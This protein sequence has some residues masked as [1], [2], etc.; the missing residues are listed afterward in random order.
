MKSVRRVR[1][2]SAIPIILITARGEE[3]Q[4]IAG[5][6][7]GADDYVVKPFS[8][9]EVV[10]RVRAQLRRARGQLGAREPLRLGAVAVDEEAR[11][12]TIDGQEVELT[13]R[14][15]DLLAALL[16]DPDRAHTRDALLEQVWGSSFLQPK[17]VDV[18]IA[19]LRRK[20]GDALEIS[21]L[22]GVGYRLE[23]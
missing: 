17:T 12:V 13:R 18:H 16:R 5:L 6:E 1:S 9:P 10:A 21:S 19:G 20:L 14:E 11:R 23:S 2:D 22:R 4:R 7:L 8:A 15:F 3:T